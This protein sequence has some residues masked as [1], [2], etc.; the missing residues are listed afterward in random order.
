MSPENKNVRQV[1]WHLHVWQEYWKV[2]QTDE[3]KLRDSV[4][5]HKTDRDGE[6]SLFGKKTKVASEAEYNANVMT[7][8][9]LAWDRKSG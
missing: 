9:T 4:R 5:R 7:W 6:F 2:A 1:V 3:N 8:T